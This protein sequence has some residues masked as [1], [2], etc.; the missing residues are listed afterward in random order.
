MPPAAR[1]AGP[2]RNC[3][4][5]R[6]RRCPACRTAPRAASFRGSHRP[7]HDNNPRRLDLRDQLVNILRAT[8]GVVPLARPLRCTLGPRIERD[9]ARG[10]SEITQ[11]RFPDVGRE[12]PARHEHDRR[13]GTPAPAQVMQADAIAGNEPPINPRTTGPLLGMNT[14]GEGTQQDRG[15][16]AAGGRWTHG[17]LPKSEPEL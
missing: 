9:D 3:P 14:R 15:Y 2:A 12:R 6:A 4:P 17:A 11:L 10:P 13:P 8:V 5:A 1:S 16:N 7:A